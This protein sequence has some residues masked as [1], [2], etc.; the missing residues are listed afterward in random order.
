MEKCF[1]LNP[2]DRCV[3]NKLVNGKQFT[4]VWYVDDNKGSHME[5][6]L[7]EDLVNYFKSHFGELVV[8]RGRKHTFLS[9]N[10]N[11][12]EVKMFRYIQKSN[13]WKQ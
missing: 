1:E 6:K 13:F 11:I 2:Y 9:V 8:N 4:L 12:T 7:S 5:F 3:A 10:I